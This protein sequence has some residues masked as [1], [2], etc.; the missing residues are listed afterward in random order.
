MQG[1]SAATK[2][3]GARPGSGAKKKPLILKK[4]SF[5]ISA[6]NTQIEALGGL[7]RTKEIAINAINLISIQKGI[8]NLQKERAKATDVVKKLDNSIL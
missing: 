4:T 3:G 2:K 7:E 6:Y 5:R 1:K 8:K